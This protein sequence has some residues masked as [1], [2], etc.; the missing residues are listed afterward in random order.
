[1]VLVARS[2]EGLAAT[3]AAIRAEGGSC[4]VRPCDM[5][6]GAVELATLMRRGATLEAQLHASRALGSQAF[7]LLASSGAERART[8]TSGADLRAKA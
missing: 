3:D 5:A 8:L 4:E 7:E 6:D 1:M 2:A